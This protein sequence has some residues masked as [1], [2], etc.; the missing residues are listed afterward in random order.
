MVIA[1]GVGGWNEM[2]IDPSLYSKTLCATVH[3]N[4]KKWQK[5]K[6]TKETLKSLLVKSVNDIN[7]LKILGSSTLCA[8]TIEK[9]NNILCSVNLGDSCYMIARPKDS[10][11]GEFDL[12]YKSEE[13]QHS[14]NVPFQIG[15]GGD[16][17]IK[18]VALEHQLECKDV[19]ILATDGLW[20]NMDNDRILSILK[21][22]CDGNHIINAQKVS[23]ILAE[24]AEKL[25]LDENYNSPF[26]INARKN[27]LRFN[28][29]KP[30][31]ISIIITQVLDK[32]EHIDDNCSEGS[33]ENYDSRTADNSTYEK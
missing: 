8:L 33:N 22:C 31:D 5:S 9:S 10:A 24:E 32:A 21:S 4:F 2:G 28:G 19:I 29:G 27:N 3:N 17:P 25:S 14:F 13:Q 20:D 12:F 16:K 6:F 7:K 26:A 1:D 23:D 18:A 11:P 30:D 15:Q